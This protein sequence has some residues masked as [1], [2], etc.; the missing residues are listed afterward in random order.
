MLS[1]HEIAALLVLESG[2]S[3]VTLDPRDIDALIDRSLV[4]A[5]QRRKT[6]NTFGLT[7]EGRRMLVAMEGTR[8][9]HYSA[10]RSGPNTS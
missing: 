5:R 9:R 1:A 7:R 6:D 2:G 4:D 8:P 10:N 3:S